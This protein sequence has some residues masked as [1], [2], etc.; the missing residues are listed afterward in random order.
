MRRLIFSI[1]TDKLN[2][3]TSASDY[4]K[5]QFRIYRDRIIEVQRG[6]AFLCNADYALQ[7]TEISDYNLLQ[8]EK[9]VLFQKAI[10]R[11]DEVLY[12]DFDV[13]PITKTN[14]FEKFDLNNICAYSFDRKLTKGQLIDNLIDPMN[15]YAKT[16]CKNAM[17][18]IDDIV[19]SNELI[20]TGVLA[21]NKKSIE[22]LDFISNL[23]DM[24][25]IYQQ[26]KEDN[27][28]PENITENWFPN[29]EAFISYLIEKNKVPFTN[30][31]IQWNFILDKF[32]PKPTAGCHFL[33]HVNKEFELSF[34]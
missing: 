20:N 30:I 13:L 27:V 34:Q 29:N 18:L 33:H 14:F 7:T 31:G 11:Y 19:G 8:F 26:A 21:G 5:E 6:Y 1:Y 32:C 12:I 16:C 24:H 22:R 3:H 25:K 9:L 4:K 17:L 2:P 23:E 28:Y 10:Q 15:V